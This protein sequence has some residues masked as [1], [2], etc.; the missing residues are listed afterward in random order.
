[1]D[2]NSCFVRYK[3]WYALARVAGW[4]WCGGAAYVGAHVDGAQQALRMGKA[5][6]TGAAGWLVVDVETYQVH[7]AHDTPSTE[8]APMQ[9]ALGN[10]GAV[11]DVAE[12]PRW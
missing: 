6:W 5:L 3:S 9:I 1:M 4:T 2:I 11:S 7:M 12:E 8:S 10:L